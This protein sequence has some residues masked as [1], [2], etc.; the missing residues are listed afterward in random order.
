MLSAEAKL[1]ADIKKEVLAET[2]VL[3]AEGK[4][5]LKAELSIAAPVKAAAKKVS[6]KSE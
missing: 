5:E 6:K 3:I 4:K 2:K 1:R